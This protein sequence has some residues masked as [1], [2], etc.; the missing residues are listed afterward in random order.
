MQTN[1]M[2]KMTACCAVGYTN[3]NYHNEMDIQGCARGLNLYYYR[4]GLYTKLGTVKLSFIN[5]TLGLNGNE[6]CSKI[7]PLMLKQCKIY[8][9]FPKR[10]PMAKIRS[11]FHVFINRDA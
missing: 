10:R 9:L 11:F 4:G 1:E 2:Y 7:T 3:Y 6:R 5:I 8:P